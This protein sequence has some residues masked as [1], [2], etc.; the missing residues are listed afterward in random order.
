MLKQRIITAVILLPLVIAGILLLIKPLFALFSFVIIIG[1][2]G[3]E[4]AR[5]AG[6]EKVQSRL[7]FILSLSM[8]A[9]IVYGYSDVFFPIVMSIALIWWGIALVLMVSYQQKM[10]FY[11]KNEWIFTVAAHIVLVSAWWFLAKLHTFN[12]QWILYLLLLIVI[13]DTA[14]YF[15]GKRFG[16]RKLAPELS[17][18][19]TTEGV[20]GAVFGV[21]LWSVL[22]I[23]FFNV[24]SNYWFYFVLLSLLT[25]LISVG[26]DLFISMMKREAGLKDSGSILPGHGG[27]LDRID[28]LL[29]ALPLFTIGLVWAG[30]QDLSG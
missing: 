26:G 28:S 5:M 17:P 22:A 29:A 20:L 21:L 10:D 25:A 18:G 14:A 27:L 30:L 1:I 16:K 11:Q 8:L 13:A 19:K 9:G 12:A 4:W 24:P 3:W 6:Y 2:G 7:L 23:V 15:S